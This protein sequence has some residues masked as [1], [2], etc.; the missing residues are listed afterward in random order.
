MD[1]GIP[2]TECSLPLCCP[3]CAVYLV[4]DLKLRAADARLLYV[5][6]QS[7]NKTS[8]VKIRSSTSLC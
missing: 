7:Q 2:E 8:L 3:P 4:V 5:Q 6:A 1:H